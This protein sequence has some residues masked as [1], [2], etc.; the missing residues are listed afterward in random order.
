MGVEGLLDFPYPYWHVD[1]YGH[2]AGFVCFL[3]F[4]LSFVMSKHN[5]LSIISMIYLSKRENGL[6]ILLIQSYLFC[7]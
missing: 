3:L 7:A 2:Y 1:L 6:L 4:H 5:L